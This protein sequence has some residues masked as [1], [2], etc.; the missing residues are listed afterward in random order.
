MDRQGNILSLN[1]QAP[2]KKCHGNR[3]DQP[4]R[5]K[6]RAEKM[7]PAKI[8]K[9]IKKRNRFQKNNEKP[10]T[11][12]ESS[13]SKNELR[14]SRQNYQE[15]IITRNLSKRKRDIS[16]QQLSSTIDL[17]IP[18]TTSSI[19]IAQ[20]SSKKMKNISEIMD[21]NSIINRNNNDTN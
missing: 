5:R 6:C 17:A 9:L 13:K 3:R 15:P 16:S 1:Q 10:T 12:I 8:K 11:N 19:S 7:K 14:S 21:N 4:F 2:R 18:K 20:S